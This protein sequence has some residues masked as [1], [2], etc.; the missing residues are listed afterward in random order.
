MHYRPPRRSA[1]PI[2]PQQLETTLEADD[3][4]VRTG[5]ARSIRRSRSAPLAGACAADHGLHELREGFPG[6]LV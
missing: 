6:G 1:H 5:Q 2:V 4:T 3:A